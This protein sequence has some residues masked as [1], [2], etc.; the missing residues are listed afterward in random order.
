[1]SISRALELVAAAGHRAYPNPTVGAVLVRDG[2]VVGG[3]RDRAGR[4]ARR[5]RRARGRGRA[6]R[7]R[8]PVRHAR[9]LRAPRV[10]A[11]VHGRDHRC[12]SRTG[13]LRRARSE[14]GSGRRGGAG[15][16]RRDRRRVRRLGR[17]A[18]AERGVAHLGDRKA[19]VRH[20]QGRRHAGRPRHGSGAALGDGRGE[21]PARPRAAGAGRCGGRRRRHGASRP[22]RGST[23]ATSRLREVSP[24]GLSSRRARSR[25]GSTSS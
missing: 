5:G 20:L 25:T 23:P 16:R 21:P 14:P 19:A 6:R 13:G 4:P 7:R 12:G 3:R 17:S 1:M 10:D 8:D 2:V 9:A 22:A 15:A 11:A 18:G 24:G